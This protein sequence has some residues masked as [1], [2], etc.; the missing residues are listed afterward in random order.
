M[1]KSLFLTVVC[2]SMISSPAFG[3]IV[4]SGSQNV[5]LQL[6]GSMTP[7]LEYSTIDIAGSGESW[8]DFTV[9]LWF[10]VMAMGTSLNITELPPGSMGMGFTPRGVVGAMGVALNLAMGTSIGSSSV[11]DTT[12]WW[13][14]SHGMG[15]TTTFG[16]FGAD[17]GYIGL[18]MVDPTT[19]GTHYGYLH[20]SGMSRI[21]DPDPMVTLD[22][23]AFQDT[24]GAP[25]AAGAIPVPGAL[26]LGGLGAC[27][28]AWLRR[29]RAV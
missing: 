16:N 9:R 22:G 5:T 12:D 25:I 17:G 24:A 7:P 10:D 29:R 2:F 21:G 18:V 19:G 26:A 1:K 8:D 3:A 15:G 23:W 13:V 14:L 27:V 20:M 11:F 6:D 28:V 4:Y